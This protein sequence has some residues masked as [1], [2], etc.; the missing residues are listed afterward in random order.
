MAGEEGEAV[1]LD[2]LRPSSR[3]VVG[4]SAVVRGVAAGSIAV[5][6]GAAVVV[7]RRVWSLR[8]PRL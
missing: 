1:L 7:D 4:R 8:L 2:L 3:V 5:V 6:A